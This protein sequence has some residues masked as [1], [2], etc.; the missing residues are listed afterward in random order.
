MK[1]ITFKR[2]RKVERFVEVDVE[3]DVELCAGV[4]GEGCLP[5]TIDDLKRA[6]EVV[7]L[8]VVGED[9][10][11]KDQS[12]K[13]W[14]ELAKRQTSWL[15]DVRKALD[16]KGISHADLATM[17]SATVAARDLAMAAAEK[18]EGLAASR[19]DHVEAL[20]AE[21]AALRAQ[22]VAAEALITK[23]EQATEIPLD[24]LRWSYVNA[25]ENLGVDRGDLCAGIRKVLKRAET[26]EAQQ[27]VAERD[28]ASSRI[29]LDELRAEHKAMLAAANRERPSCLVERLV[30]A[31]FDFRVEESM[32]IG[33]DTWSVVADGLSSFKTAT[34]VPAA[35]VPATLAR[36][37]GLDGGR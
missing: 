19:L 24:T 18:A 13:G 20:T 3:E 37:A 34:D 2:T 12:I 27:A 30:A 35:S 25:C 14:A 7:G 6:C 5:A 11:W 10:S 17:A 29:E 8:H 32:V 9:A 28:F 31:R 16:P 15:A 4:H 1:S 21:V 22:L 33:D 23:A 36:L 26:A